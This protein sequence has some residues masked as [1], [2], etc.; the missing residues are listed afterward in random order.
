MAASVNP[1]DTGSSFKGP[2]C[3]HQKTRKMCTLFFISAINILN[4]AGTSE[5]IESKLLNS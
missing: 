1:Q 3:L 2:F 4:K 5:V